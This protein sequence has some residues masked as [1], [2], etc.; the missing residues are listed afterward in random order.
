MAEFIVE[1]YYQKYQKKTY[2]D[3][4]FKFLQDKFESKIIDIENFALVNESDLL[5]S[6]NYFIVTRKVTARR[7]ASTYMGRIKIL[8]DNLW[9]Y[10]GITNNIYVNGNLLP[11]FEEKV[12]DRISMLNETIDKSLATDEQYEALV[13]EIIEFEQKYS[14]EEAKEGIDKFLDENNLKS[15]ALRMFRVLCSICATQMVIEYGFKNNVVRDI[16]LKDIDIEKGIIIRNGY[17]LPLSEM[18][19]RNLTRY[20]R[21]RDYILLKTKRTQDCLFVNFDGDTFY[22]DNFATNLFYILGLLNDGAVETDPFARRCL[23]EMI[24]KGFNENLISE[25]TGYKNTVYKKVCNIVNA[26]KEQMQRK[27]T[28]F[29]NEADNQKIKIERKGY[30]HCPMCGKSIKAVSDELVLIKKR[31]DSTLYLACKNCGGHND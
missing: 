12:K 25:I 29:V 7:T 16:Q 31:E 15:D 6:L 27:I 11:E 20:L 26:N 24:E 10:Y 8:Y 5:E 18:L 19:K 28:E 22:K 13:N 1:E 2:I 9:K 23:V 21:L 30:I 4:F 3:V 14:Y 17:I